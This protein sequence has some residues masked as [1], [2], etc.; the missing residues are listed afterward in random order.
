LR[1]KF[2]LYMAPGRGV[3]AY[4]RKNL[5]NKVLRES[6]FYKRKLWF[7]SR[8]KRLDYLIDLFKPYAGQIKGREKHSITSW[9]KNQGL[10]EEEI[11]CFYDRVGLACAT[12]RA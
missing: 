3:G 12:A 11:K 8:R 5:L 7:R 2:S 4:R 6:G 10:R 1:R 9:L